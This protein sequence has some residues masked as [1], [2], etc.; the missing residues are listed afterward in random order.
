[1]APGVPAL[2][3]YVAG[4]SRVHAADARVKLVA[5]LAFIVAVTSLPA[6]VWPAYAAMAVGVWGAVAVSR[7][8]MLRLLRRSSVAIPFVLIAVPSVFTRPGEGVFELGLGFAT[9]TATDEGLV[10]FASMVA[11][12]WMSVAA[13]ALLTAAT[14]FPEVIRA[15]RSVG[16]PAVLVSVVAFMYRYV[17]V[18]VDEAQRLLRAR[19]ARSAGVGAGTG[20]TVA[21]RA[22]VTGGMAGSLFLRTYERS[23]R[24]YLAMLARGFDGEVRVRG[25]RRL[26]AWSSV[27]GAVVVAMCTVMAVLARVLS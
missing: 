16:V 24:I 23:E 8:G 11:K 19:S 5:T 10:F 21:W 7:V 9:L 13:A 27:S 18:L 2:D 1:M 20:G 17:F 6:G 15:L 4:S 3:R 22:R 12:S 25:A 26:S 14:P